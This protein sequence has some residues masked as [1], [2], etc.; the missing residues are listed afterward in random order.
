MDENAAGVGEVPQHG[1]RGVAAHD[2]SGGHRAGDQALDDEYGAAG[3]GGPST[4][5]TAFATVVEPLSGLLEVGDNAG[6]G[7][8]PQAG[9]L[10]PQDATGSQQGN[11]CGDGEEGGEEGED[12]LFFEVEASRFADP[13]TGEDVV[14]LVQTDVTQRVRAENEL[15]GVLDVEHALLETVFPRCVRLCVHW[16]GVPCCAVLCCGR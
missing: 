13:A 3:A 1:S 8:D 11:G 16:C 12:C 2:W 14:M 4:A 6:G 10:P 9:S 5:A 7:S 15:K